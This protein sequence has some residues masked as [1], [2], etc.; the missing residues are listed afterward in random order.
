MLQ[1]AWQSRRRLGKTS[2]ERSDIRK[3]QTTLQRQV[4]VPQIFQYGKSATQGLDTVV[5]KPY[6]TLEVQFQVLHMLQALQ[7]SAE[8]C[9]DV[10]AKVHAALKVGL[11]MFQARWTK[12][13]HLR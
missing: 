4:H 7:P 3:L 6:G 8:R 11:E 12:C 1:F 5:A 10:I 13:L 2:T 9:H